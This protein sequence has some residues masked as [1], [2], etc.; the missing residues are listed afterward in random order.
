MPIEMIERC[1]RDGQNRQQPDV[2]GARLVVFCLSGFMVEA[3]ISQ[4]AVQDQR[5]I[6]IL[7]EKNMTAF[8]S[9]LLLFYLLLLVDAEAPPPNQ[10]TH[11]GRLRCFQ[12]TVPV[13]SRSRLETAALGF[14]AGALEF[15]Q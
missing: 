11:S 7:P 10:S 2:G 5:T 3:K 9:L 14:V 1:S 15:Y 4:N 6:E 13:I 8:F 12:V